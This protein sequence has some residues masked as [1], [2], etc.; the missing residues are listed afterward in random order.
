MKAIRLPSGDQLLRT[1]ACTPS[2]RW[3]EPSAF[4]TQSWSPSLTKAIRRPSGETAGEK[5]LPPPR[6]RLRSPVPSIRIDQIC[7]RV[8]CAGAGPAASSTV[9]TPAAAKI[10]RIGTRYDAPVRTAL[11]SG[12]S[13]VK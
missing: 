1:S 11:A 12:Q 4:I 10:V 8:S 3:L 13:I 7:S 9:A 2:D 6:L 5:S